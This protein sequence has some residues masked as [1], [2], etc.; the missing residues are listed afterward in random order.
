MLSMCAT[1]PPAEAHEDVPPGFGA[2]TARVGVGMDVAEQRQAEAA[3]QSTFEKIKR[4]TPRWSLAPN[5]PLLQLDGDSVGRLSRNVL[6]RVLRGAG[7]ANVVRPRA[8]LVIQV[9]DYP[10]QDVLV[11][12]ALLMGAVMDSE[13][14]HVFVLELDLVMPGIYRRRI[15][16]S[17]RCLA[18]RRTF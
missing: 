8:R 13:Y 11:R 2:A 4:Q 10:V 12:L 14:A 16:W 9:D 15:E 3:L 7:Y 5:A 18:C 17:H 6:L 1:Y